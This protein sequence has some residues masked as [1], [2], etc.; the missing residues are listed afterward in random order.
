MAKLEAIVERE[1]FHRVWNLI[2]PLHSL[3]DNSPVR[4]IPPIT[5]NS[6][7]KNKGRQK[8]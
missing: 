8:K 7:R 6:P 5:K 2:V 4:S 1:E 3:G